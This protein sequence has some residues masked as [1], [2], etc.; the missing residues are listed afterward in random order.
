MLKYLKSK[1]VLDWCFFDF[2]ISSYPTLILTFFYGAFYAK[3]IAPNPIIG[4][5][6]WG[7]AVASASIL[8]FFIF[9]FILI[10]A[11]NY[12]NFFNVSLF[13]TFFYLMIFSSSSLFLFN[14]GSSSILPLVIV[15]ISFISFE[16]VNL[17]YNL[18]LHK[19]ANRGNHGAVS[20]LGWGFGY[21]GGLLALLIIFLLIYTYGKK[22]IPLLGISPFLLVG[23]FVG[24]WSV[25]FGHRHL[26]NFKNVRFEVPNL[27]NFISDVKK[28]KLF[29]FLISYFFYNNA[30]IC[31]FAFASMF[32]SFL[33]GLSESQILF[34]GIFINLSG[35]IGCFLLGRIEDRL[36]SQKILSFCIL[37]LTLLTFF[38]FFIESIL[39]FWIIA[40][41]IGFFIGPIQAS[42]R[43]LLAK[44]IDIKNQ[45][46]AFSLFSMFGNICA[47]LG[48]FLIGLIIDISESIRVGLLV[49]PVFFI[50][51]LL[52]IKDKYNIS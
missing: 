42:S 40:I 21:L 34:L 36:G 30:V 49:I 24:I 41:S 10:V 45:L 12:F 18:S 25:F 47:V 14:Q 26:N 7:F 33:F 19:V 3:Y 5:S 43:S 11:K 23:P 6:S 38:L 22:E 48:P 51:A 39:L 29:K 4:T 35:V 16:V 20:N 32:A 2:G 9:A 15:V 44:K 17:F 37:F 27:I 50:I 28:K 52:T 8:S 1:K 31:I 13:K 46:S